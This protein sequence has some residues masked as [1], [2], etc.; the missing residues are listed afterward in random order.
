MQCYPADK[1]V[2]PAEDPSQALCGAGG[3]QQ[4]PCCGDAVCL[5]IAGSEGE[6]GGGV[7]MACMRPITFS[8]TPGTP[9]TSG[10]TCAVWNMPC[11]YDNKCCD[12]YQCTWANTDP[13]PSTICLSAGADLPGPEG[14]CAA[15]NEPC[16]YRNKCCETYTCTWA[17]TDPEPSTIC[18]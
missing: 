17:N 13:E 14:S 5:P 11:D 3:Q 2:S 1:C 12:G 18:L 7:L 16:D 15:V 9:S 4:I 8:T 6:S 10:G